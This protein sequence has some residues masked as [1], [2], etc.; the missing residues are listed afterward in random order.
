MIGEKDET[1]HV[2][3][4]LG[5]GGVVVCAVVGTFGCVL[6]SIWGVLCKNTRY[7]LRMCAYQRKDAGSAVLSGGS[8]CRL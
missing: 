3:L 4:V 2:E 7:Y 8:P 6:R 5:S 1:E